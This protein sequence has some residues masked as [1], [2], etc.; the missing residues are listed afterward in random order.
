[1]IITQPLI[2]CVL[3]RVEATPG[4]F[5]FPFEGN[6]AFNKELTACGLRTSGLGFLGNL[7]PH[8]PISGMKPGSSDSP[9]TVSNPL[10]LTLL[11]FLTGALPQGLI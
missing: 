7:H 11:Q 10:S 2:L 3:N 9:H 5:Y 1:M 4:P 6:A 8:Y